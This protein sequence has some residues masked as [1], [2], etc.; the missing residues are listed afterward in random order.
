MKI[1]H[2]VR[3]PKI[4]CPGEKSI[5]ITRLE[6]EGP[7]SNVVIA[8]DTIYTAGRVSPDRAGSIEVQT[9]QVLDEIDRLMQLAGTTRK[10]LVSV[11]VYLSDIRDFQGMNEAW[12]RWF[13]EGH[14]PVRATVEARLGSPELK[15]EMQA[16][17]VRL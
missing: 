17:A 4:D 12:K 9:T 16:I 5:N 13:E 15:V 6:T 11:T 1:R 8:N 10:G 14:K 3:H 2:G 7:F